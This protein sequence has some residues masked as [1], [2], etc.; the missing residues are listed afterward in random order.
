MAIKKFINPY[1]GISLICV[2]VGIAG[3]F[4]YAQNQQKNLQTPTK[5]Y[6]ELTEAEETIMKENIKAMAQQQKQKEQ[7]TE[8]TQQTPV[9]D[10]PRQY[11]NLDNPPEF[12]LPETVV[13]NTKADAP[14]IEKLI[15][16]DPKM[17][18]MK[19]G[20]DSAIDPKTIFSQLPHPV[21]VQGN[22]EGTTIQINSTEDLE[23]VIAQLEASD[24]ATHRHMAQTLRN[25]NV[26]G[27][28]RITFHTSVPLDQ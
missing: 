17:G 15:Q 11:G 28:V 13:T 16:K 20:P 5:V 24:D 12:T 6:K 21:G 27:D 19:S 1:I 10:T 3:L 8:N 7:K 23:R 9:D 22:G 25:H 14:D 2:I 4:I 18:I 26:T